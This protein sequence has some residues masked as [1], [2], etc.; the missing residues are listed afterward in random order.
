MN[1]IPEQCGCRVDETEGTAPHKQGA[2]II[3][4]CNLH[5]HA[6]EMRELLAGT[7]CYACR[8]PYANEPPIICWDDRAHKDARALL[9]ATHA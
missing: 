3:V 5:A 7:I 9:E 4:Q 1:K 2:P 6:A 8:V